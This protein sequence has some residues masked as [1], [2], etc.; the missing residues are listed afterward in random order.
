MRKGKNQVFGNDTIDPYPLI[1]AE[2]MKILCITDEAFK[3]IKEAY[4]AFCQG[5]RGRLPKR[6]LNPS[7][8]RESLLVQKQPVLKKKHFSD[9]EPSKAIY[10]NEC[11][12]RRWCRV[13]EWFNQYGSD[14]EY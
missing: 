3:N 13:S 7:P 11:D 6:S 1:P 12:Y 8:I 2:A 4:Q 14:S 9:Y 10:L 5:L